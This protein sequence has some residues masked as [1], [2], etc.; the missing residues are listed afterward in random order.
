MFLVQDAFKLGVRLE[1]VF[2][3]AGING[4]A[5]LRTP[6]SW[7]HDMHCENKPSCVLHYQQFQTAWQRRASCWGKPALQ[8]SWANTHTGREEKTAQI[9]EAKLVLSLKGCRN[10]FC[11][12]QHVWNPS[13]TRSNLGRPLTSEFLLQQSCF[14]IKPVESEFSVEEEAVS[15]TARPQRECLT[16]QLLPGLLVRLGGLLVVPVGLQLCFPGHM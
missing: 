12:L 7:S 14:V 11:S 9:K 15:V 13:F 4:C 3:C 10:P 5:F 16:A 1:A 8:T 2:S 6:S